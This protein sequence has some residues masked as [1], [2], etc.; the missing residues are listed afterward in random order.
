MYLSNPPFFFN[1]SYLKANSLFF[2]KALFPNFGLFAPSSS[3]SSF[4][5]AFLAS[6]LLASLS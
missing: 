6:N 2:S 1:S 4:N 3:L 5:L